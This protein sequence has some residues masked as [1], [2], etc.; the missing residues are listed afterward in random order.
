METDW[1]VGDI[2]SRPNRF[3]F[4]RLPSPRDARRSSCDSSDRAAHMV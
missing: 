1:D 3:N 2:I 4:G